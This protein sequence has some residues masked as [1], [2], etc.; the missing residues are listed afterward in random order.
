MTG[1]GSVTRTLASGRHNQSS[2]PSLARN[3]SREKL[4]KTEADIDEVPQRAQILI[5]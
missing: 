5:K 2:M 4:S 1:G 3:F